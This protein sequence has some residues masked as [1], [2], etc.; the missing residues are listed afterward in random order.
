MLSTFLQ[1]K[2]VAMFERKVFFD[3][4]LVVLNASGV[5]KGD[6]SSRDCANALPQQHRA[7][8]KISKHV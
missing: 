5:G 3:K 4:K 8:I 2:S 1:F 7:I 6:S